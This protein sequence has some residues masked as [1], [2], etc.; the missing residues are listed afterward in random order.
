MMF[1]FVSIRKYKHLMRE[2]AIAK[3][4][5]KDLYADMSDLLRHQEG[6]TWA[7]EDALVT[8]IAIQDN[9]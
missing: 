3:Q 6:L 9:L 5:Q 1:G 8:A 4:Q 2:L 7:A